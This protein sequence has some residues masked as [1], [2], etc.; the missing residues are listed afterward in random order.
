MTVCIKWVYIIWAI[1]LLC[2]CVN[3]PIQGFADYSIVEQISK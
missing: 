1:G 2:G 3:T